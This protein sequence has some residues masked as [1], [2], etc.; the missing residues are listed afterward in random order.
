[1]DRHDVT[2]AEFAAF[3][4][5]TGYATTAERK[6]D[7][8]QLKQQL[9]PDTPRPSDERLVPGS[10][11]FVASDQ[12]VPLDDWSRWW[13]WVPGAN[14]RH[15]QGPDSDIA[16]QHDYP[17][18]QVSFEDARAY[19]HWAG[20]RLP[21]EAEWEFA[22]RGGLA[23]KRY[24]WGDEYLPGGRVMANTWQGRFPVNEG[25]HGLTRVESYPAN[26]YGLFDMTGN[27][28]QWTADWYRADAFERAA[29]TARIID[30]PQGPVDSYD[31]EDALNPQAA[32]E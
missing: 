22:A 21:T 29:S 12:A 30:N 31:P 16:G 26:G 11:V 13:R 27:A 23:G 2:N 18:V 17:V 7:W 15:P 14:W 4:D 19:A 1:M 28:W 9:P 10:L 5:A 24:A 32:N 20:Q 6:P 3:V 8:D 25:R